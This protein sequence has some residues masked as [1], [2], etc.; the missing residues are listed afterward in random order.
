MIAD[1]L[2]S[3][4]DKVLLTTLA[5]VYLGYRAWSDLSPRERELLLEQLGD[6]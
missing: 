2:L 4:D 3:E 6:A 1:S 5:A